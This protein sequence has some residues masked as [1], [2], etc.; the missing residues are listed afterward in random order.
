[1]KLGT[2]P[3]ATLAVMRAGTLVERGPA[4]EVLARPGHPYTRAWVA[5]DPASWPAYGR[6]RTSSEHVLAAHGLAFA[7]DCGKPLF[8]RLDV[9]VPRGGVLA[10]TGPS[11]SGKSTLG[12]V[13]LGLRTPSAGRVSWAGAE[14]RRPD[15][16]G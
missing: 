1:M 5:A 8:E 3:R 11:G 14:R 10:L 15:C 2:F 6:S 9:V 7:Y 12:D 16:P 4:S 13:L